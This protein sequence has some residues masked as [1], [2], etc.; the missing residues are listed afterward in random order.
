MLESKYN[1]KTPKKPGSSRKLQYSRVDLSPKT[2][3]VVLWLV[4]L[5]LAAVLVYP[6]GQLFSG[7]DGWVLN[8]GIVFWEVPPIQIPEIGFLDIGEIGLRYY[9]LLLL[10]GVLAGYFLANYLADRAKLSVGLIDKIFLGCLV[11]GLIGARLVYVLF[12]WSAFSNDWAQILNLRTGGLSF[13]GALLFAGAYLWWYTWQHK[14]NIYQLLDVIVPGLLLGQVIARWGNLFNYESYGP[15]TNLFWGM[16]VPE[17]ARLANGY[18]YSDLNAEFFHPTFLYES[19]LNFAL[20]T[21]LLWHYDQLTKNRSGLVFAYYAMGY[22]LIRFVLEFF[23][24]DALFVRLPEFLHWE[25]ISGWVIDR[26]LV[27]QLFALGLLVLGVY[28]WWQRQKVLF[29]QR[30]GK[31]VKV[32]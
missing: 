26:F 32:E 31:E 6:L 25:P 30:V 28:V 1:L 24:L 5:L 13:F 19:L 2:L 17:S 3:A 10:I 7:K 9:A 23:R 22:G 16:Y 4:F 12:N 14:F 11:S 27:S 29:F 20:L 18:V 21:W 15:P 8:S